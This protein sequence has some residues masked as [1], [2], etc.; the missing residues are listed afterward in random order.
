MKKDKIKV[1]IPKI[2]KIYEIERDF[3][4]FRN[5]HI[6]MIGKGYSIEGYWFGMSTKIE[7]T[8]NE[9]KIITDEN[10]EIIYTLIK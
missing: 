8:E 4:N 3:K 5:S 7:I 2:D 10:N 1:Y 6:N 9:F